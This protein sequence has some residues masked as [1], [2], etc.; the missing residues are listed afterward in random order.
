[1]APS[2]RRNGAVKRYRVR[3]LDAA[4]GHQS[5]IIDE[6]VDFSKVRDRFRDKFRGNPG[7]FQISKDE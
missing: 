5:C 3:I 6:A 7:I 4:A 1:M 2:N